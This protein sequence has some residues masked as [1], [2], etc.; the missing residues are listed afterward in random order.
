MLRTVTMRSPAPCIRDCGDH[1]GAGWV[2]EGAKRWSWLSLYSGYE[3][4]IVKDSLLWRPA[5]AQSHTVGV[6]TGFPDS[7]RGEGYET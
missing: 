4:F 6:T 2:F 1:F 5:G 3:T 7:G